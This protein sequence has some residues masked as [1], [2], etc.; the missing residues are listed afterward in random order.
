MRK[1]LGSVIALS[2]LATL[3]YGYL[4]WQNNRAVAAPEPGQLKAS[5]DSGVDWLE[6]NQ[7]RILETLNPM[8]WYMI[9]RAAELSDDRRLKQLFHRCQERC[10]REAYNNPL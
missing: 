10:L 4:V 6:S 1:L 7:N 9:Q 8:L 5:L 2:V 3:G